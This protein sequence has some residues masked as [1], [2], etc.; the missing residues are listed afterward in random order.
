MSGSF[1]LDTNTVIALWAGDAAL[2]EV[3]KSAPQIFVPGIVL[4]EL[5][6]GA[7][8]SHQAQKILPE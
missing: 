8:K 6:S 1:L 5:Y 2:A 3:L 7:R 4:G